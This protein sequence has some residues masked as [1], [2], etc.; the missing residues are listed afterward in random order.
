MTFGSDKAALS[1]YAGDL[2]D[3]SGSILSEV[4]LWRILQALG[5]AP[6]PEPG[7][8]RYLSKEQITLA[9]GKVVGEDP[10]IAVPPAA[11]RAKIS[12]YSASEFDG[13]VGRFYRDGTLPTQSEGIPVV[14]GDERDFDTPDDL[15]RWRFRKLDAIA[16]VTIVIDF[17]EAA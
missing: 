15:S 2:S 11:I 9:D 7:G 1:Q 12:I 3:T 13:W 16:T 6:T 10:T 17:W 8:E 14:N 4:I 5:G